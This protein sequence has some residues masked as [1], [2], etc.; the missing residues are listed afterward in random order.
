M[1]PQQ[2]VPSGLRGGGDTAAD[3]LE[4]LRAAEVGDQQPEKQALVVI[5]L[6]AH[7]GAGSGDPFHESPL[8]QVPESA[9][10]RDAGSLELLHEGGFTRKFL[11]TLIAAGEDVLGEAFENLA[12]FG[13][14]GLRR[15]AALRHNL[16]LQLL[17]RARQLS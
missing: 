17:G 12:V 13:S 8:R 6:P 16:T 2:G 15:K 10:D 4:D 14:V 3:R 5:A 9:A 7:I 11:P 1:T